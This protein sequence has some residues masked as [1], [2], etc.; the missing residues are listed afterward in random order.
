[1]AHGISWQYDCSLYY[2]FKKHYCHICQ[3]VLDRKKHEVIV[4]PFS[5]E[6]KNYDF[7]S[8]DF[9]AVC[10]VKFVTFYFA[11]SKCGAVYEIKELKRIEKEQKKLRKRNL[12]NQSSRPSDIK[13]TPIAKDKSK[14][15]GTDPLSSGVLGKSLNRT[16]ELLKKKRVLFPV[17]F[18]SEI[19]LFILLAAIL[20][21]EFRTSWLRMVYV[22]TIIFTLINFSYAIIKD[23][24]AK[25]VAKET[26]YVK[27]YTRMAVLYSLVDIHIILIVILL[28]V[29]IHGPYQ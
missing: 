27:I 16:K 21:L 22:L 23:Y 7:Y 18:F 9:Y 28:D 19:A 8:G 11:C 20:D 4:S 12:K 24:R 15:K 5:E 3:S 14:D 29:L 10:D 26:P 13:Q 25:L 2:L 6:A 17:I 1:M